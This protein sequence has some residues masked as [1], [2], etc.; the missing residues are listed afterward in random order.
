MLNSEYPTLLA[1]PRKISSG[2]SCPKGSVEHDAV[3]PE[4]LCSVVFGMPQRCFLTC[5]RCTALLTYPRVCTHHPGSII[6][7]N[8]DSLV[9]E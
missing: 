3:S 2:L 6:T 9:D 7:I 1:R 5:K 8:Q 4:N